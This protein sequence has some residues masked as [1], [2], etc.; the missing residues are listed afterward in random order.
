[1]NDTVDFDLHGLASVRLLGAAPEDIAAVTRQ[2]GLLPSPLHGQPDIVIR[3]VDELP[4]SSRLRYLGLNDVAYTDDAFLVL[5][6]KH[7]SRAK[8]KIPFQDIG[9]RCE[10]VCERGLAAVPLLMSI[11]N[12][13]VLAKG[14]LPLHASAFVYE[15]TGVLAT[16]WSKGGKTE[17]LLAFMANGAA[18]VGDDWVYLS[19]DG[20]RMYGI[21]EPL[22]VWD[23]HLESLPQFKAAVRRKD[24]VKLRLYRLLLGGMDLVT[25]NG[26]RRRP[27]LLRTMNRIRPTL[28]NQLQVHVSPFD[29]FGEKACALS[30]TVERLLF[31]ASHDSPEVT[32]R[33]VDSQEIARRMLFSLQEEEMRLRSYYRKFRFAFP[34]LSN[35]VLEISRELQEEALHRLLARKEAYEVLHPYPVSLPELYEAVRPYCKQ[36]ANMANVE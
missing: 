26:A 9:G 14:A 32:V 29:L 30:G 23:W 15:G 21:P 33:P 5:Q 24:R 25:R 11:L 8:V 6:S 18:Y 27:S 34:E 20:Q 2:L 35:Q 3:F 1:M 13:T 10:I 12:L 16:G 36:R 7:K 22:T 4:S 19:A 28:R 17:T 31:V